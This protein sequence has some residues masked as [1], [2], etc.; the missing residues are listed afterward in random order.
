MCVSTCALE[1][2]Y[3]TYL[4]IGDKRLLR[5][6][7][8]GNTAKVKMLLKHGADVNIQDNVG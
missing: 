3:L 6:A 2:I 7:E 8:K 4:D 1:N 5:N